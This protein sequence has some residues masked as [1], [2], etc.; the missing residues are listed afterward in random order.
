MSSQT[1]APSVPLDR[2][3]ARRLC[4]VALAGVPPAQR[5]LLVEVDARGAHLIAAA[6]AQPVAIWTLELAGLE[7]DR[8]C[9]EA[10]GGARLE[11]LRLWFR[12]GLVVLGLSAGDLSLRRRERGLLRALERFLRL[13]DAR[14]AA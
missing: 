8:A 6:G 3:E 10:V 9:A 13:D 7:D 5:S 4:E 14:L 2:D 12:R 1:F 11:L